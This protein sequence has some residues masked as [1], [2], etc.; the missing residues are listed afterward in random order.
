MGTTR[1]LRSPTPRRIPLPEIRFE[2]PIRRISKLVVPYGVH[3]ADAL[4]VLNARQ[5]R[6]EFGSLSRAALATFLWHSARTRSSYRDASGRCYQSRP[7]PSAGACHPHDL[8]I[9]Q[10]SG[11]RPPAHI[12][13]ARAHAL[14]EV[15]VDPRT[16]R[17][18]HNRVRQS[19][20]LQKGTLIWV[21]GHPNR[22]ERY[23]WNAESLL[24][25]DAGALLAIMA[26]AAEA[27][28]LALCRLA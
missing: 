13:D 25:R 24:W 15:R 21:I 28:Q 19:L 7:A 5:T 4:S 3:D 9:L 2:Y 17:N 18:L 11:R 22:T 20:P 26:L 23:Y 10:P 16:L 27:L 1:S 6:R 14:A 8:L 12:Y